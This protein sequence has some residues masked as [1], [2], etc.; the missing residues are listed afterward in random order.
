MLAVRVQGYDR[1]AALRQRIAKPARSAAPLPW[2]GFCSNTS[3]P[4][5]L[6]TRAVS[7]LDPSS[8]TNTGKCR[9][10]L[11]QPQALRL[12]IGWYHN[13]YF[14]ISFCWKVHSILRYAWVCL[15]R[16]YQTKPAAISTPVILQIT[17]CMVPEAV[18]TAALNR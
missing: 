16:R 6:P 12:V 3:A 13:Q 9:L 14:W 15:C 18:L 8:T 5:S 10:R 11:P 7:S 2:L 4:A 17:A 1:V